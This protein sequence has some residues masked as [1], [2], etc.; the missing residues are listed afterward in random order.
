MKHVVEFAKYSGGSVEENIQKAIADAIALVKKAGF[1][2]HAHVMLDMEGAKFQH[3]YDPRS[4]NAKFV[5]GENTIYIN[6]T[7]D[8]FAN[9]SGKAPKRSPKKGMW[10]PMVVSEHPLATIIHE[11]GHSIHYHENP[12][13]FIEMTEWG[14]DRQPS[15]EDPKLV[16]KKNMVSEYGL[17]SWLE[18]VAE[19]FTG[20]VFKM[21]FSEVVMEHY[22][23]HKGPQK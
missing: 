20:L 15:R 21:K 4:A 11:I 9:Y 12:A 14:R 8:E 3:D 5:F 23:V 18:F 13:L 19:V 16:D 6:G 17:T 22:A 7:S 10:G 2:V 1:E